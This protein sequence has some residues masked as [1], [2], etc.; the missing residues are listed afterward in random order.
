MLHLRRKHRLYVIIVTA[1]C[2]MGIALRFYFYGVNRSLWLDEA[3]LALNI[4]NRSII[5][6]LV[7]LDFNQGAPVGF[8]LFQ[9]V[10]GSV[11]GYRDYVLRLIPLFAGIL[12]LPLILAVA[13]LYSGRLS[14][15]IAVVLAA[16]SSSLIYYSS[17]LKQYSSDAFATL[18]LLL[19]AGHCLTAKSMARSYV[20]LAVASSILAWF[21]HPSLFVTAGIMIALLLTSIASRDQKR[22]RWL[23]GVGIIYGANVGLTYLLNLRHLE[24][25][26]SLI[27]YWGVGFAPM[28]PWSNP[29]WFLNAIVGFIRDPA[30]ILVS[31]ITLALLATGI[32][33]FA[34]RRWQVALIVVAPFILT[35][36]ASAF[37][38]YPFSGRLLL[39]LVPLLYLLLAEGV[40]RVWTIVSRLSMPTAVLVVLLL[41]AYLVYEPAT[42]SL[43]NVRTPPLREHIK[44]VMLNLVENKLPDDRVY[45]YYGAVPAFTFYA[46]QLGIDRNTYITGV[47]SRK[48][49]AQYLREIDAMRGRERVWLVF[50]HN[51]PSCVVNE[52][53]YI[54]EY[55]NQIGSKQGEYQAA[56]AFM[57]LY[58]LR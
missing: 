12:V 17:E 1:L 45:V 8:L 41:S 4:V 34:I 3:W 13:K 50:A 46:P 30:G 38:K 36:I 47:S 31:T 24:S 27:N 54:T 57:V 37:E 56:G 28:L 11:L 25:N 43:N 20:V 35:I 23:V 58:D 29:T 14:A 44:P 39:F 19:I 18:V 16:V 49:P 48:D 6:L 15:V 21:S 22:L 55:L 26:S 7:P 42:T 33:S 40:G 52:F 53:D 32:V 9:K 51:C 10:V 2:L 5:G